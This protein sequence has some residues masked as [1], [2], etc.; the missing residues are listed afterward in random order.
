[1]KTRLFIIRHAEAEGNV[2]RRIHGRYNSLLT[3]NG[4]RQ[5]DALRERFRGEHIDVCYS[6]DLIRARTTAQAVYLPK[7]L[8]LRLDKRLREVNLGVW[9]DRTF[10]QIYREDAEQL[11]RFNDDPD[12]WHVEGAE[13][14][15][16]YSFRF[17][18][19]VLDIA[20]R[21]EGQSAAIF[22]H[23][24]VIRSLQYRL[25]P[26]VPGH[27]DN[28]AVSLLEF[29]NGRFTPVYL[30]DN[31]HL[32]E[33]VSTLARQ[34]WWRGGKD[35]NL[36]FRPLTGGREWYLACREDAWRALY[37]EPL[38]NRPFYQNAL[39][40][41]GGVP[42]ALCDVMLE[43]E[44]VGLLHL[45]T[46]QDV[47]HISFLYLLPGY[48]GLGLGTQL[49]GQAVSVFRGQGKSRMQLFV[50]PRNEAAIALYRRNGF[51]EA[52]EHPGKPDN[53]ILMEMDFRPNRD[54]AAEKL[55]AVTHA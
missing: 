37:G 17:L 41:S 36:W 15:Q 55:V 48:R 46:Q 31:G 10:G 35:H 29:E 25:F 18:Q 42:G 49:L 6:S 32:S 50:S 24:S 11:R 16:E 30:D 47:G 26:D 2:Y 22:S 44:R 1:M 45:N 54:L 4:L 7:A 33:E 51:R 9:E 19:A 38:P 28:T 3:L 53:L 20:R 13:S 43:E 40:G 27:S 34:N 21:H 14:Y 12:R 52:G 8:P 5:V 39:D 23:G